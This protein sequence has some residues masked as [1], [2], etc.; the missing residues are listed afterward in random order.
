MG[1]GSLT[2]G[3]EPGKP[4]ASWDKEVVDA[5][6]LKLRKIWDNDIAITQLFDPNNDGTIELKGNKI[7]KYITK[8]SM[9]IDIFCDRVGRL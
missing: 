9:F 6:R 8:C 4:G 7:I 2:L 1:L 5:I 3:L